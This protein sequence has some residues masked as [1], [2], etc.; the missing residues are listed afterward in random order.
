MAD[1]K[2]EAEET[3]KLAEESKQL[4]RK[5]EELE[6]AE[7]QKLAVIED[8]EARIRRSKGELPV[9]DQSEIM[10]LRPLGPR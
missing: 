10:D 3:K 6:E 7:A 9:A 8:L 1:A 2:R 5:V 4:Q